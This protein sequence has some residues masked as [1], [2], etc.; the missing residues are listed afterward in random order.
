MV[1]VYCSADHTKKRQQ[2]QSG[3][4]Y[5]QH[6]PA[7]VVHPLAYTQTSDRGDDHS[8]NQNAANERDEPL[9]ASHPSG[10][11]SERIRNIRRYYQ[12]NAR[13]NQNREHPK[14][15]RDQ[16][17]NEIAEGCFGP[18]VESALERQ[19]AVEI[20]HYR[21]QREIERYDCQQPKNI[22]CVTELCCPAH[23]DRTD[24]KDHLRENQI[25]EA[26]FF[27]EGGAMRFHVAFDRRELRGV[28]CLIRF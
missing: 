19:Q 10:A 15:P 8:Q 20:D 22:L 12:T 18:L 2:D 17:R 27:L 14:I 11:G 21:C 24:Y 13:S 7:G 4:G 3:E 9:A 1:F 16:E 5:H 25:E 23:P 26:E 6:D 28:W